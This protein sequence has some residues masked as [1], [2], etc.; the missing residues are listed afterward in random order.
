MMHAQDAI[1]TLFQ[2]QYIHAEL[3]II[4]RMPNSQFPAPQDQPGSL[5]PGSESGP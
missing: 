5:N 3:R 1:N 2:M 4:R